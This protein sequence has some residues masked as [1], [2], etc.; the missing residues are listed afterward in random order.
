MFEEYREAIPQ[1]SFRITEL[2]FYQTDGYNDQYH[3]PYDL[4]ITPDIM[5]SMT[6]LM[7]S[8]NSASGYTPP[9]LAGVA[10]NAM[11]LNTPTHVVEIA[12]GWSTIRLL[13]VLTVETDALN[14]SVQQSVVQG[15]TDYY[16]PSISEVLAPD[17]KLTI[18]NITTKILYRTNTGAMTQPQVSSSIQYLNSNNVTDGKLYGVT[19]LDS[20]MPLVTDVGG[21]VDPMYGHATQQPCNQ[22]DKY[23]TKGSAR[24][25]L[26]PASWL[27]TTLNVHNDV[28][29]TGLN[30]LN[31]YDTSGTTVDKIHT[32]IMST[33]VA[34]L[35]TDT[36]T[37]FINN[38]F[39]RA[40]CSEA[41]TNGIIF[42][43]SDLLAIDPTI[44]DRAV[45]M[46]HVNSMMVNSEYMNDTSA[47]G[48]AASL[49]TQ[50]TSSIVHR[51][52]ISEVMYTF[53]NYVL[54]SEEVVIISYTPLTGIITDQLTA[55]LQT[56]LL[57]E[58]IPI[59]TK[60]NTTLV[61]MS[62]SYNVVLGA[63]T[64][65]SVNQNDAVEYSR[66]TYADALDSAMVSPTE[67][68]LLSQ[69][70]SMLLEAGGMVD[71]I[72]R[73][74]AENSVETPITEQ[75]SIMPARYIS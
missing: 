11:I 15:H 71:Q 73:T 72:T 25:N 18:N 16:D 32:D 33:V 45:L 74:A 14:G 7:K 6:G 21:L 22:I 10:S 41:N 66:P 60:G 37:P 4:Q 35:E 12:N 56:A 28:L 75:T 44:N 68:P 2:R 39:I 69:A 36:T 51:L 26:S 13:F 52:N 30:Q 67:T 38:Q 31:G 40:L 3:R 29:N 58:L 59:V 63:T 20:V 5:Q 9:L 62:M 46:N 49:A 1:A 17:A 34:K 27:S 50:V 43:W 8:M 19:P 24:D 70:T 23:A 42:S 48:V 47:N 53:N 64:V 54:N 57:N 61:N 65:V 55:R